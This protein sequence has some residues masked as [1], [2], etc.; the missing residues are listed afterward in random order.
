M[1][2]N[3]K[4]RTAGDP[5]R[6]R[7]LSRRMGV[8][9]AAAILVILLVGVLA[10][11]SIY[12]Q[13][14]STASPPATTAAA[15]SGAVA[16]AKTT[17][18]PST[19]VM[20]T[21]G[22][23][24]TLASPAEG[25]A[26]IVG[27]SVVNV[28]VQGSVQGNYGTQDY[29]GEG[30]GVIFNSDGMIVTNNHVVSQND[31]PATDIVVTLATGEK[32]PATIV[33]RDP[34]TDL[35]VIKIEKTGLTPAAFVQDMTQVKVGQYAIAIGSPL[36]YSNSVT[37]GI[38][39]GLQRDL[40][41]LV[42]AQD[43]QAY[44]DLIQTDAA[45]SPGNSGGALVNAAGQVIGINVAYMPPQETGAQ[46]LGFA[47]PADVVQSTAQQLIL[48]GKAEHPYLGVSLVTVTKD[49]QSRFNLTVDTGVLVA[50]VGPGTPAADAGLQQ[51][52]VIVK[53]DDKDVSSD[54]DLFTLLRE[55]KPGDTITLTVDREGT[56]STV[57][58]TLGQRPQQ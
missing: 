3:R 24:G 19:A 30:S 45:I 10:G 35:A 21:A 25:V 17:A 38:V 55:H 46:N 53:V 31:E 44:I 33:G 7:R 9:A 6:T 37:M 41:S 58:V 39:S 22:P 14:A 23:D 16:V 43:A 49:L 36:G 15:G 20:T 47:I 48:T 32:L 8:L 11:C 4:T 27:P 28:A 50:D 13:T 42:E 57:T 1:I 2:F 12:N 5:D 52:D 51:G 54:A 18:V 26:D 40:A 56:A 34:L 29:S